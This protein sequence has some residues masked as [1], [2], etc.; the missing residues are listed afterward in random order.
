MARKNT[1]GYNLGFY[2]YKI[3]CQS[4]ALRGTVFFNPLLPAPAEFLTITARNRNVCI[5]LPPAPA[6]CMSTPACTHKT[7]RIYAC[8]I[9]EIADFVSSPVPQEKTRHFKG[10]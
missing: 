7:L 3:V 8:T 1:D 2:S 4:R 6:M 9:I 10:Y 5:T